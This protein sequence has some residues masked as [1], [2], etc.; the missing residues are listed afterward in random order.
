M[1]K[2]DQNQQTSYNLNN[3]YDF[4]PLRIH[5]LYPKIIQSIENNLITF[6][7]TTS[8][9]G[10]S[11]QVPIF[12]YDLLSRK[13]N[14]F[15]IIYT[16]PRAIECDALNDYII[17]INNNFRIYNN[18]SG[19]YKTFEKKLLFLEETDLLKLL[20]EDPYLNKCDILIL[21]EVHERTINL[22]LILYY[23]KYF[24]LSDENKERGF[25]LIVMS[26]TFNTDGIY[27]YFSSL[28]ENKFTFGFIDDRELAEGEKENYEIIYNDSIIGNGFN[29]GKIKFKD[30]N[31]NKMI[32]EIIQIV[33]QEISL[34]TNLNKTILIFLPDYKIIYL[35]YNLLSKE[36]KDHAVHIYQFI[37]SL[38]IS[39]QNDLLEKIGKNYKNKWRRIY[40]IILSESLAETS[41]TFPNCDLVI[42]CGL[43]KIYRYN[44]NSNIYEDLIEYI[45]QDSCI[46]RSG[47]CSRE[48]KGEKSRSYRIFSKEL[49]SLMDKYRKPD[50]ETY[51][52]DLFILSLFEN[53]IIIKH[54]KEEI[55][56]KGYIDFLSN[57]G[58]EK[59]NKIIDRLTE[60]KAIEMNGTKGCE[61][62]TKFGFWI[63]EAKMDIELGYYFD[64]FKNE[65][66]E[67]IENEVVLQL[68]NIIST[69][70]NN[71]NEL[72]LANTDANLF[73][74][75]LIDNN[76]NSKDYKTL[77][78]L[79]QNI[80]K[81]IIKLGLMDFLNE[82]YKE[83]KS[84]DF[85][86]YKNNLYITRI[87]HISPYYYLYSKLNE[88]YNE[89]NFYTRNKI[90]QLGDWIIT[91]FF[92]NQY[93][94]IKCLSHNYNIED[95]EG[96][97]RLCQKEKSNYCTAY[98]LNEKYF[99]NQ[100]ISNSYIKSILKYEYSNEND[101]CVSK[102]EESLYNKWNTIYL[103]LISN[104]PDIYIDNNQILKFISEFKFINFNEILEELYNSYKKL[105]ISIATK[106]LNLTNIY[107]DI[108]IMKKSFQNNEDKNNLNTINNENDNEDYKITLFFNKN[109]KV[110]LMKGY[111][112][113]LI[114]K[115]ID[116]YFCLSKFRKVF[117]DDKNNENKIMDNRLFFKN[118]NP[119]FDEMMTISNKIN[120]HF[121][122]LEAEIVNKKG[123]KLYNDIG[124]YFYY[125]FISPK[126]NDKNIDIQSNSI[127]FTYNKIDRDFNKEGKISELIKNEKENSYNMTDYIHC[128][129]NGCITIEIAQGLSVKN[130]YD[131]DH[132]RNTNQNELIYSI[133]VQENYKSKINGI[134]EY[135]QDE[136][137]DNKDLVYEKLYIIE[138][139]L[140]IVFKDSFQLFQFSKNQNMNLKL[141]PFK[142]N[143]NEVKDS[144]KFN[145]DIQI[146]I[147]KFYFPI[148]KII[149]TLKTYKKKLSRKYRNNL[150]YFI[151]EENKTDDNLT[152]VYYY[153]ISNSIITVPEKAI[154]G[155]ECEEDLNRK[156]FYITSL[157]FT[158]D[159]DYFRKFKKFCNGKKITINIL[160]EKL[161][162]KEISKLLYTRKY[163]LINYSL[164][165]I[166][167]IQNYIG[168]TTINLDSLAIKEL[169]SKCN[170]TF[171]EYDIN[172][173]KYARNNLCNVQ[174]IYSENKIVIYGKP[175][176]RFKLEY[177]ISDYF[178]ELQNDKIIYSL[179]GKEDKS[180][181]I[182]L[183]KK[184]SQRQIV[185]LI[186]YNEQGEQQLEFRKKYYNLISELLSKKKINRSTKQIKSTRCEICFEKLGNE[187][188]KNYIKLK[189]CGHK[190][191][192][193]CLKMQICNSLKISSSN[194]IPIKC[195][196]CN[197][198]IL[199]NDIFE[200]FTPNTPDYDFMIDKLIKIFM[201]KNISGLNKN[202]EAEYY[203]CP[204]KKEKCKYIYSSKIKEKGQTF[205]TCPN[206]ECKI[207][208]LCNDLIDPNI[209]HNPDC[210]SK[211]FSKI[212]ENEDKLALNKNK[213]CPKCHTIYE[214]NKGCN[215]ITCTICNPPIHFCYLCGNILNNENPLSHFSIKESQCYNK[216]FDDE[217]SNNNIIEE[218]NNNSNVIKENDN[219]NK[220]EDHNGYYINDNSNISEKEIF[221]KPKEIDGKVI[222]KVDYNFSYGS[223]NNE[224]YSRNKLNNK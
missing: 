210:Q 173:F 134:V 172:I 94:L 202:S 132:N 159:F 149:E 6:I 1:N 164:E 13:K 215:K 86:E 49:Y 181:L 114:P 41:L 37:S 48:K 45:S 170:D 166:K 111:F 204:N 7:S 117:E 125:Y 124:K 183:L 11:T 27:Y 140:I 40:N 122:S 197:A 28:K 33:R 207:C 120:N 171:L 64:R 22:E 222:E 32:R 36:Y 65:Y 178:E 108:L 77:V 223:N 220:N 156:N 9:S 142:N 115:E 75:N 196:K 104:K 182:T 123:I 133:K 174:I 184:L 103:N 168:V 81:N 218:S 206:C 14:A 141:I 200:I 24:T 158:S 97:C 54:I 92:I 26:A 67:E 113:D 106:Y 68:L 154:Y 44:Y 78:D 127:I 98:S 91:L 157:S 42:D 95:D 208:L 85:F 187:F 63:L 130:I 25:K 83:K 165:N 90:F 88:I 155:D 107:D 209:K 224:K 192:F 52:I 30:L 23:I 211:L 89:K 118:I 214:K 217:K 126:I 188:N 213:E 201:S 50:I 136:I 212:Y 57:I 180:L 169:T 80:S 190:F 198:I 219:I 18:I 131:T 21:D 138:D 16:E 152:S 56:E 203:S 60:Y 61:E 53:E 51:N 5:S 20:K 112:F 153:F 12:S 72:I 39:Q 205:M 147:V 195:V 135:Y 167:L 105:Y 137:S 31:M 128:L 186:S 199:N 76:K 143:I 87:N 43:K 163:G 151:D 148:T 34:N 96:Y 101:F 119:I 162:D 66:P 146:Y 150:T 93:R 71:N 100:I 110:N 4:P 29:C 70:D 74:F 8:G 161:N 17:S 69:V 144:D 79:S 139:K 59:F 58:K 84:F 177:I 62:I 35:L 10:K 46:Q 47:R 160:K 3:Y 15:C 99:E 38:S 2:P 193:D 55:K 189:L 116:K 121:D 185:A 102:N 221:D 145:D 19:Y 194:S 191:C 73:K 129:K 179:K 82:E 175:Q 176:Y 109:G 216:L